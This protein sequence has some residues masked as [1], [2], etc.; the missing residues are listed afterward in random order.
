MELNN[1]LGE[2]NNWQIQDS[3]FYLSDTKESLLMIYML[4]Y[5]Q[6]FTELQQS[7]FALWQL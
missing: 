4:P 5:S 7:C 2:L 3:N 1:I 6:Q